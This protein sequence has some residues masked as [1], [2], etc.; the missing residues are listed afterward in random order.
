MKPLL[1]AL[2]LLSPTLAQGAI[3]GKLVVGGF[4]LNPNI[5][6]GFT[7]SVPMPG[8]PG[9]TRA[10]WT[11]PV[12]V[13][14]KWQ[15]TDGTV[16]LD[17]F[18]RSATAALAITVDGA[19]DNVWPLAGR[20]WSSKPPASVV[21]DVP[22]GSGDKFIAEQ[23]ARVPIDHV[24]TGE[25]GSPRNFWH[26]PIELWAA[27]DHGLSP[28]AVAYLDAWVSFQ[29]RRPYQDADALGLPAAFYAEHRASTAPSPKYGVS[30]FPGA[31]YLQAH[32]NQHFTVERLAAAWRLTRSPR[33]LD[34]L[35]RC[36]LHA[37]DTE[38][39][40]Q[41]PFKG[42]F[43]FA[44][45]SPGWMLKETHVLFDVLAEIGGPLFDELAPRLVKRA[46]QTI[47]AI[48]GR[49]TDDVW[50]PF[51]TTL[52]ATG[53]SPLLHGVAFEHA[54]LL[55]GVRSWIG[56]VPG[57]KRL[58]SKLEEWIERFAWDHSEATKLLI[59]YDAIAPG[60]GPQPPG[61]EPLG[62]AGWVVGA[63][64]GTG[65]EFELRAKKRALETKC[66]NVPEDYRLAWWG[67]TAWPNV[68]ATAPVGGGS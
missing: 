28:T 21:G 45:R 32:D 27:R 18:N 22:K 43:S 47:D 44:P 9:W 17:L 67:D 1:L 33:A 37:L 59:Y 8:C 53:H 34:Q 5:P 25:H 63:M 42:W 29:V 20:A 11:C 58:A 12:A 56:I 15:H 66:W 64:I 48:N 41:P 16:L 35:I 46:T 23:A 3:P 65:G 61:S 62:V 49:W 31:E 38:G 4:S 40:W 2:A 10:H 57:A 26:D 54:I 60:A 39:Y 14:V 24:E 6:A 51:A 52:T 19:T 36:A 30:P 55:T 7:P 68:G 13:V 50:S